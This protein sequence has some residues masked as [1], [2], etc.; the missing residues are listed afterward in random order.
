MTEQEQLDAA[1]ECLNSAYKADPAAMHSILCNIIPC[2]QALADHPFV[3]VQSCR[4]FNGRTL[5]VI[6]LLNGVLNAMGLPLIAS[7][8]QP[9]PEDPSRYELVG[10][11]KYDPEA[12]AQNLT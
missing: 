4:M 1:T 6:G 7:H 8:Y 11:M 9:D 5:S 2:N 10:F 3:L 12:H